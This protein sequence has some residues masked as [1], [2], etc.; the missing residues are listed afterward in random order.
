MGV[1]PLP[2]VKERTSN[3]GST[4]AYFGVGTISL[5][6]VCERPCRHSSAASLQARVQPVSILHFFFGV[7]GSFLSG[8]K[9]GI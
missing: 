8:D 6:I 2:V 7:R 5:C 4:I 3:I 9:G 1:S